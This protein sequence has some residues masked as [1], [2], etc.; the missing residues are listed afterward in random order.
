M[1]YWILALLALPAA[2]PAADRTIGVGSFD[3]VRIDGPFDV[4]LKSGSPALA[5]SGDRRTI[6]RVD[7][8]VEGATLVIRMG[9]G[10]WGEQPRGG[11]A[12]VV[13][14]ASPSL[15][16]VNLA[17]S[18]RVAIDR[19]RGDRVALI[20]SGG[21]ALSVARVDATQV[22]ATL[23]GAGTL[24]I[25]GRADRARLTTRGAGTIDAAALASGDVTVQLDGLGE[26]RATA[27]YT[28]K[29]FNGGLGRV[30]IGGGGAC[31]VTGAGGG[32]VLCGGVAR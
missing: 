9:Q 29:V 3:R 23:V 7:A 12:V 30:T 21:G 16:S 31:T 5:L 26:T 24:S 11:G 14:A 2:A 4:R 28:A 18:G 19:M 17:G 25:A 8:H 22:D 27:R 6:D 15:S 10:G 13:T 1:R 32:P 20:L